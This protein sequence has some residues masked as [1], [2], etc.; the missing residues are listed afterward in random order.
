MIYAFDNCS[1][2][3]LS[4]PWLEDAVLGEHDN[5]GLRLLEPFFKYSVDHVVTWP[6]LPLVKPGIYAATTQFRGEAKNKS[7]FVFTR[8]DDKHLRLRN[9]LHVNVFPW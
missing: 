5:D 2:E 8:V 6:H 4:H 1:A 7:F 9:V 3:F